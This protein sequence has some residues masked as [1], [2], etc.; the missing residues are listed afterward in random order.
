MSKKDCFKLANEYKIFSIETLQD[1]IKFC[2]KKFWA[3]DTDTETARH[4][5]YLSIILK[6]AIKLKKAAK[7][8]DC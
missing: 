4:Y 5:F 1:H 6:N 3:L 8:S 2:N 7:G